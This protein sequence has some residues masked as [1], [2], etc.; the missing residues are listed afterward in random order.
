MQAE[1]KKHQSQ[2]SARP[3]VMAGLLLV[4]VGCIVIAAL[5]FRS[6]GHRGKDASERRGTSQTTI[7]STTASNTVETEASQAHAPS[8]QS[9]AGASQ[10]VK[11]PPADDDS[12]A[13]SPQLKT[14][15]DNLFSDL[16]RKLESI[17][18]PRERQAVFDQTAAWLKSLPKDEAAAI[19]I[20][21]LEHGNDFIIGMPFRVGGGGNLLAHPTLRVAALDWLGQ[22]A[23]VEAKE[24]ARTIFE[25]SDSADEWA[26]ALR[27]YGRLTEP[28]TDEYFGQQILKLISNEEWI[29]QMSGGFAEAHD[30]V[31]F[32]GDVNLIPV[33]LSS[34]LEHP[35]YQGVC[36][37]VLDNFI[38]EHRSRAIPFLAEHIHDINIR[39][40]WR[41]KLFSRA[42]PRDPRQMAAVTAYISSER[43]PL[44]EKMEF[45]AQY[46]QFSR[47]LAHRLL[48][49]DSM[50]TVQDE[51]DIHKE[52]L[53]S[54]SLLRQQFQDETL[55]SVIGRIEQRSGR[56][57]QRLL[58]AS[59]D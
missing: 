17:D 11:A 50:F 40:G 57:L 12:D 56:R 38:Q 27:N 37:M 59:N 25:H 20:D 6:S 43:I 36:E 46:P 30:I 32:E 15:K 47:F 19:I 48:T 16:I 14:D 51:I 52:V 41:I 21:F 44:D 5:W 22:I 58:N 42:D 2:K 29:E 3:W 34:T 10:R 28:G 39:P 7:K 24:Y 33:M 18:D 49:H 26:L 55:F 13:A 53:R 23:A 9:T 31:V 1:R 4:A 45:A 8:K 54:L 35:R